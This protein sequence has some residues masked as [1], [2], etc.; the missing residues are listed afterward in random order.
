MASFTQDLI[1]FNTDSDGCRFVEI[2]CD[3]LSK[4]VKASLSQKEYENIRSAR[5]YAKEDSPDSCLV[6]LLTVY[7]QKIPQNNRS[8][9]PMPMKNYKVSTYWSTISN[10]SLGKNHLGSIMKDISKDAELS[11]IYTNHC[12]RVT[13]ISNMS[14]KGYSAEEIAT[15]SGHKSAASVQRY[16]RKLNDHDKRKISD[17]LSSA[18]VCDRNDDGLSITIDNKSLKL[19]NQEISTILPP[20]NPSITINF[21]G[22]FNNCT[23]N[24]T[25]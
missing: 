24:V 14:R 21:T 22:K 10:K 5:I 12:V 25:K 23:F 3:L 2:R 16:V 4:N 17:D 20:S 9:F 18:L 13:T 19:S 6:H 15:V 8:L 11:T 1:A 7:F